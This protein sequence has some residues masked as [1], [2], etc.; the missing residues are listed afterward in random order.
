MKK[1]FLVPLMTIAVA[2]LSL[3]SCIK[4]KGPSCV[5]YTLE[6]D[7]HII[8][9]FLSEK[10]MTGIITFNPNYSAYSGITNPGN[11]SKPTADSLISYKY[12]ISLMDGTLVGTTDTISK[13]SNT[14]AALK[15]GDFDPQSL[16]Y[17]LFSSLQKGGSFR[18]IVPS[19]LSVG[20]ISQTING[21]AVPAY[22]QIIYDYNL[23]SVKAPG[24]T[25]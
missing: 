11:G 13:N 12:S 7:K 24:T 8:D 19:S 16:E 20:C 15:L 22:S 1:T 9:S 3:A 4:D 21:V 6:Q 18:I 25:N 10:G 2:V 17:S 5:P 23:L 14:G